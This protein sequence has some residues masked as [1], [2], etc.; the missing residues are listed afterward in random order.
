MKAKASSHFH[1][2]TLAKMVGV[3]PDTLRLYERKG[4][5]PPPVRSTNGYRCYSPE[6]V[7]KVRLIRSAV[8]IGFT[9]EE[10]ATILK[11]RNS[12]GAPCRKVRDLAACKLR[13]IEH[14]IQQMNDLRDQLRAVLEEWD[15]L[16]EHTPKNE[17]AD[18]LEK[19][20]ASPSR[21]STTLPRHF[22]AA[23]TRETR[24]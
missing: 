13:G 9:L 19:L 22:Y 10:L 6:S 1:S 15:G 2:G 4:L 17:R 23:L 5:L 12:G 8:S 14:Q 20:A 16:L 18:L 7:A 3:S 11:I 21:E 24:R